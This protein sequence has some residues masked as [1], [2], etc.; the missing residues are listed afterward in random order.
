MMTC[1]D[2]T[3]AGRWHLQPP[4]ADKF[5]AS[6]TKFWVYSMYWLLN[7]LACGRA[8]FISIRKVLDGSKV[9]SSFKEEDRGGTIAEALDK[10]FPRSPSSL[11]HRDLGDGADGETRKQCRQLVRPGTSTARST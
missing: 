1:E 8:S 3:W 9:E 5:A 7:G 11:E 10:L 2:G 4:G 6:L